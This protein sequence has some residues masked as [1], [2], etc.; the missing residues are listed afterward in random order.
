MSEQRLQDIATLAQSPWLSALQMD[1]IG[2]LLSELTAVTLSRGAAVEASMGAEPAL[3][4]VLEG[5]VG[6]EGGA[7]PGKLLVPGDV[8]GETAL[9]GRAPAA[10][11]VAL[12]D[13]RL[14]RLSQSAY[15]LLAETQPRA[16]FHLALGALRHVVERSND[17]PAQRR[18]SSSS[19]QA[20]LMPG[21]AV[22]GNPRAHTVCLADRLP[23]ELDGA[24]VVAGREGERLLPLHALSAVSAHVVPLTTREWEGRDVYR[25]SA[26]LVLLEA[27]RR[28]GVRVQLGPSI[29]SGRLVLVKTSEDRSALAGALDAGVSAVIAASVP[30]EEELW[31]VPDAVDLFRR[32]DDEGARLLL[33]DSLEPVATLLRCGETWALAPRP[34]LP[35]AGFLE[36]VHVMPHPLGLLLDFGPRIR[37]ELPR[38]PTPTMALELRAPRYGAPMTRSE[39]EWMRLLGVDSVGTFNRACVQ[40]KVAE[41]IRVSEGFHEKRIA[42]IA[43]QIK[44]RTGV[45]I[46]SVARDAQRRSQ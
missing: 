39:A 3:Y 9:V 28:L 41:L 44:A 45:R 35:H 13:V 43:D 31:S 8:F 12:G 30:I 21:S 6:L 22:R 37:E 33:E 32:Q 34:L 26:G 40:G 29:T 19:A 46:V 42:E 14:A 36:D 27:A 24:L 16:A 10:R 1:E 18:G 38:R 25:R 20:A 11:G 2:V 4:F 7:Q 5:E 23:R 17:E 15:A